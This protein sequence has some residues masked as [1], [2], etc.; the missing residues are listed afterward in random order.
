[1]HGLVLVIKSNLQIY[2]RL[3]N[4]RLANIQGEFGIMQSEMLNNIEK[5]N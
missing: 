1:M 3:L 4:F 2:F 5:K